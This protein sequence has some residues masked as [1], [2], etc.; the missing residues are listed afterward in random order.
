[1]VFKLALERMWGMVFFANSFEIIIKTMKE[2]KILLIED[3]HEL[4]GLIETILGFEYPNVSV[5]TAYSADEGCELL[6]DGKYDLVISDVMLSSGDI[7]MVLE[8]ARELSNKVIL[9][10]GMEQGLL[11][12][13]TQG[14]EDVII[15]VI[16]K[17]FV[18]DKFLNEFEAIVRKFLPGLISQ[19]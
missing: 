10:T 1:M 14:F 7:G 15:G 2:Y 19:E 3:S 18:T 12:Q 9:V 13:E 11:E 17:P 5:D 16:K 8:T 6:R 4:S